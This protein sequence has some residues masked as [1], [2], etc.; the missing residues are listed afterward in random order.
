[1]HNI[2]KWSNILLKSCDGN[3]KGF[4]KYVWPFSTNMHEKVDPFMKTMFEIS[5]KVLEMNN[6][7]EFD[8]S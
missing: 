4:L 7:L 3:T 1:M 6:F 5:R 8:S 2:E